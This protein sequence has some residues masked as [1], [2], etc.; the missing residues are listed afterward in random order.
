MKGVFQSRQA[1]ID[2]LKLIASQLIVLHHFVAYGPL[3]DALDIA[4]TELTDWFYEYAR[5]AVQIFL[6]LGGFLAAR[7]LANGGHNRTAF[8]WRP[9]LLRYQRLVLPLLVALCMA[10]ISAALVRP[11]LA[12]AFMPGVPTLAQVL[13]H[14]LLLQNVFGFDSL[15]AGIW[16]VAID[17]QLFAL[18]V[19][20]LWPGQNRVWRYAP[21]LGV[22][23]AS[24][25]FFNLDE[26]WDSWGL[27]F[28]GAYGL[29]AATFWAVN[30]D[31]RGWR[32]ILLASVG[33]LALA[34]DFRLRIALALVVALVLALATLLNHKNSI[35]TPTKPHSPAP[36]RRMVHQLGHTSYALFLVHFSVLLL[37]NALFVY[38]RLT[39]AL[40]AWI[41]LFGSWMACM[42]MA[43]LFERWVERPLTR[44]NFLDKK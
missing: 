25:F 32:L 29:G 18:L 38:W 13:A 28:F 30:S 35:T 26:G 16:Y 21:V 37:C 36:V 42:G 19:L 3:A 9:I 5:M 4:A 43:T 23:L 41:M 33:W 7:S 8:P 20:L 12:G 10:M 1:H 31:K 15:A 27:Y 39:G 2:L 14:S 24:L 22:M 11:W 34:F 6:V 44:L 17:F 40:A